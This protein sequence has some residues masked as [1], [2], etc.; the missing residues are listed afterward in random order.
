[1]GWSRN[2]ATKLIAACNTKIK[3]IENGFY[4]ERCS[5]LEIMKYIIPILLTFTIFACIETSDRIDIKGK[6]YSFSAEEGYIEY[7]IDSKLIKRFSHNMGNE[8]VLEYSIDNDTLRIKDFDNVSVIVKD[9]DSSFTLKG[10]DES[11]TFYKLDE[12]IQTYNDLEPMNDSIFVDFYRDFERR[13]KLNW[14]RFGYVTEEELSKSLNDTIEII[15]E[16]IP[17]DNDKQKATTQK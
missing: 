15:E 17:L 8:S 16:E 12:S 13:A 7:V 6:W 11:I 2:R 10:I 4:S 9:S 3:A 5:Q 1:M 14:I